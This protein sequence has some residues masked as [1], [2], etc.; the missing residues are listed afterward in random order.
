M[1]DLFSVVIDVIDDSFFES[2][3]ADSS[4]ESG[5]LLDDAVSDIFTC[6]AQWDDCIT[7]LFSCP[8][9]SPVF[10]ILLFLAILD[11]VNTMNQNYLASLSSTWNPFNLLLFS[12]FLHCCL[13]HCLSFGFSMTFIC[14]VLVHCR[15][16]CNASPFHEKLRFTNTQHFFYSSKSIYVLINSSTKQVQHHWMGCY[17][18]SQVTS[19]EMHDLL[20]IFFLLDYGIRVPKRWGHWRQKKKCQKVIQRNSN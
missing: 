2:I 3:V 4:F 12:I 9:S 5:T 11:N 1:N 15:S 6:V 7:I 13:R 18:S 10:T 14:F 19:S 16:V 20:N 8:F 17:E